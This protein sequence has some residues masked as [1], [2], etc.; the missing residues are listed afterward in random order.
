VFTSEAYQERHSTSLAEPPKEYP[1]R[2]CANFD[3]VFHELRY[4]TFGFQYS[5]LILFCI[6]S[7]R[8]DIEPA[9]FNVVKL[10]RMIDYTMMA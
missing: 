6:E 4:E 7:K 5:I 9:R 10:S 3:L 2:W 1:M 8:V